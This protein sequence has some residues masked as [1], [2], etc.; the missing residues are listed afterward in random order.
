MYPSPQKN[1]ILYLGINLAHVQNLYAVNYDML[2]KERK[3]DINGRRDI[4]R[5]GVAKLNIAKISILP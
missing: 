5:S 2:M 1:E 4:S 3:G